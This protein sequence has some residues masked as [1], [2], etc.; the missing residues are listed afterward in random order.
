MPHVEP[1]VHDTS[2][3]NTLPFPERF[4]KRDHFVM[5][6]TGMNHVQ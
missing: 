6:K 3:A 5:V 4:L 1:P 2:V